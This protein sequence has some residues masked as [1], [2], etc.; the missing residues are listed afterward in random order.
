MA[1]KIIDS[2]MTRCQA[3]IAKEY[4][5][6]GGD[7]V[8]LLGLERD[9]VLV[10]VTGFN[11]FNGKSAH[12]HFYIKKGQYPTKN[13]AWFMFYYP[14][15]QAGLDVLIAIIPESNKAIVR[16]A[17]HAG[18]VE[19]YTLEDTHPDGN[20][21]VWTMSKSDCKPLKLRALNG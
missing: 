5:A 6:V 10:A 21:I 16:L 15:Y 20:M 8:M 17:K 14:F 3:W 18:Y 1:Y 9:G 4:G 12:Q 11:Y 13:F 7:M 19:K 2:D